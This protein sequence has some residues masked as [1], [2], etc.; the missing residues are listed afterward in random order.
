MKSTKRYKSNLWLLLI[1]T[2][3]FAF[4]GHGCKKSDTYYPIQDPFRQW[5]DFKKG[6]YWIFLNEVTYKSDSNFIEYTPED[7]Y[8]P[9]E[10]GEIHH[11]ILLYDIWNLGRITVRGE[12]DNS[13]LMVSGFHVAGIYLDFKSTI[14][15]SDDITNFCK[16]KERLDSMTIN[17]NVIHDVIHT[18]DT[19]ANIFKDFYFAKNVGIIKCSIKSTDMD[20]TWSLMRW[21]VIQ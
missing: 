3:I 2:T 4:F 19:M 15:I 11:E 10:K 7:Y 5:T 16:V 6:S 13:F 17:G 18:R 12:L 14:N 20:T 21:H 8:Y 9:S 1:I